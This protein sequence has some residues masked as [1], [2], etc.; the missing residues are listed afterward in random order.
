MLNRYYGL[1]KMVVGG[2]GSYNLLMQDAM[3]NMMDRA[4]EWKMPFDGHPAWVER[5]K[6]Y[7]LKGPS[8]DQEKPS[9]GSTGYNLE[10]KKEQPGGVLILSD[11]QCRAVR[12]SFD[13]DSRY[14][15]A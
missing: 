8:R 2:Y 10:F 7:D 13:A 11:D 4:S 12:Q 9:P 5:S 1:V 3:Y 14:L 15:K 6:L